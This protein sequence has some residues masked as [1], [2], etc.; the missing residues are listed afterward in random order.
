[1]YRNGAIA[2]KASRASETPASNAVWKV[3]GTKLANPNTSNTLKE[4]IAG[5]TNRP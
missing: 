4:E 2:E 5:S 3:S 1:M